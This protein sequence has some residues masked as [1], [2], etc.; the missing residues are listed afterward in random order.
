[1]SIMINPKF[2]IG[3]FVYKIS[4]KID[5]QKEI[6]QEC[7]AVKHTGYKYF[8]YYSGEDLIVS[9][10]QCDFE[11]E[12]VHYT[13]AKLCEHE[14]GYGEWNSEFYTNVS[15]NDL[16]LTAGEL[17]AECEKRNKVIN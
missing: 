15:E 4:Q 11:N 8:Y 14:L 5:V 6:C 17:L 9:G 7:K 16:F 1:M 10:I 13:L 3:D 12:T 2:N